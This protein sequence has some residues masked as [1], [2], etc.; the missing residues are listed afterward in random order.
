MYPNCQ[1]VV[2]ECIGYER[3]RHTSG[4]AVKKADKM[5]MTMLKGG[6]RRRWRTMTT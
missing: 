6:G 5:T 2:A 3:W 1:T 4:P